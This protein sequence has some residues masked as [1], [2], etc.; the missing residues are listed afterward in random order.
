M[1]DSTAKT[2]RECMGM[3]QGVGVNGDA[4]MD[5]MVHMNKGWSESTRDKGAVKTWGEVQQWQARQGRTRCAAQT[6][7]DNGVTG[8]TVCGGRTVGMLLA[9][10][11]AY[12]LHQWEADMPKSL[13]I[14]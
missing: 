11:V 1:D 6:G 10:D 14:G 8:C 2:W 12:G 4:G 5:N 3:S 9:S 13:L 7:M